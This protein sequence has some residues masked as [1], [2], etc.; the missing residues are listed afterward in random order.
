[1]CDLSGGHVQSTFEHGVFVLRARDVR[2]AFWHEHVLDDQHD[3]GVYGCYDGFAV[4]CG[5]RCSRIGLGQYQQLHSAGDYQ[6]QH[7][8]VFSDIEWRVHGFVGVFD[9]FVVRS[10]LRE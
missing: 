4:L 1:M 3:V 2:A 6:Q 7:D 9:D 10:S 8:F 5:V